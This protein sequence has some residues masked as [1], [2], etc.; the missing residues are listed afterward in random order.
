MSRQLK[1]ND[2]KQSGSGGI[3]LN[4]RINMIGKN[5]DGELSRTVW[6]RFAGNMLVLLYLLTRILMLMCIL[7]FRNKT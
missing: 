1:D 3:K 4:E 2:I 7:R 5:W 6:G